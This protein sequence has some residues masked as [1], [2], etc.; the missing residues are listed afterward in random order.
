[1]PDS[2]LNARIKTT[3]VES[4]MLKIQPEDIADDAPLFGAEGLGLDSID[5]LELSVAVDKTFGAPIPNAEVARRAF[6]SVNALA[7]H[8]RTNA[9][10]A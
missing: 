6:A 2:D 3:L 7:E 4:L 9:K 10:S 1:M 8:I 5:A